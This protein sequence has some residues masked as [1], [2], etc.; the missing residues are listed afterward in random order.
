MIDKNK[1]T[2]NITEIR[3]ATEAQWQQTCKEC[4]YATYF[5]T[6]Q[7]FELFLRYS[8]G[9]IYPVTKKIIFDDGLS[10][11]LPLAATVFLKGALTTYQSS[12]A[13]TFGGWISS[14][15]LTQAHAKALADYMLALTNVL[16]RENPYD[17]FL[18]A[19]NLTGALHEFTQAID[20]TKTEVELRSASSRAHAK[21]LAKARREGVYVTE[22]EG[23]SDWKQH[24]KAYEQS[25]ARWKSSGTAKKLNRPYR[26]EFFEALFA[27][28]LPNVKLWCARYKGAVAASVICFYW[29]RHVVAWHGAALEE[30]FE[31]R[32]NN[33]LY[34][35]MIDDA[36]DNGYH[37]FDCNTPGGL[38]GVAEFKDHLGTQK[39]Q[40]R[41]VDK[42]SIPRRIARAVKKWF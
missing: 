29:N 31:V 26:W 32:P 41:L 11:I 39:L 17:P 13:G 12:P 37:W 24:F 35:H 10:A 16:W 3:H 40:S 14:D 1:D 33:A 21:A 25:L 6:P 36:K 30:Y 7:W 27:T 15:I 20:L 42:A 28:G 22:A 34:Q 9:R 5:H 38:K 19:L 2:I 4:D 8:N 18:K 23:M